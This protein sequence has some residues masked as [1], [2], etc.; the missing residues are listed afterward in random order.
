MLSIALA[1]DPDERFSTC[2]AFGAA[3]AETLRDRHPGAGVQRFQKLMEELFPE[4]QDDER[5]ILQG[6]PDVSESRAPR[7]VRFEVSPGVVQA[8]SSVTLS[9]ETEKATSCLLFR[10]ETSGVVVET[11]ESSHV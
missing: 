3:L 11:E 4:G 5:S 1:A 2:G 6:L 10:N 9:W 7:I 8:G